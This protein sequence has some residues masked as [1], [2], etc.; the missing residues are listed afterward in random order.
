[1]GCVVAP[2][3]TNLSGTTL[4]CLAIKLKVK[5]LAGF[6]EDIFLPV[7]FAGT[8][9]TIIIIFLLFYVVWRKICVCS[10]G[11]FSDKFPCIAHDLFCFLSVA[12]YSW[13]IL[14]IL[15]LKFV[16]NS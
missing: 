6:G 5:I 8:L 7:S 4:G 10:S 9:L 3:S 13:G 2:R 16:I 1:M 11:F 15:H 12:C 14:P